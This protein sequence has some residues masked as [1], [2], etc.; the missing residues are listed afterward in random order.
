MFAWTCPGP[1]PVSGAPPSFFANLLASKTEDIKAL[2]ETV[3]RL[4]ADLE[5][6][7]L[8]AQL[9]KSRNKVLS[10][11]EAEAEGAEDQ[12][13]NEDEGCGPGARG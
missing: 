5:K 4:E 12:K 2:K 1:R 3:T 10:N 9:E 6:A 11:D 7:R 8:E 13:V